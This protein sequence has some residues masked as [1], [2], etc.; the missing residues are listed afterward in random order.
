M[1]SFIVP[2]ALR[3]ELRDL[4]S[5]VWEKILPFIRMIKTEVVNK[6]LAMASPV[7]LFQE[8]SKKNIIYGLRRR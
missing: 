1:F 3:T 5:V 6:Y 8:V 2:S 4:F 7:V